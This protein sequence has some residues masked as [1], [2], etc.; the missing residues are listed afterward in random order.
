MPFQSE[1]PAPPPRTVDGALIQSSYTKE[2][3]GINVTR[4]MKSLRQS[5]MVVKYSLHVQSAD[6][7]FVYRFLLSFGVHRE[8]YQIIR[9][10]RSARFFVKTRHTE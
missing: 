2:D 1:T 10:E 8:N 7:A 9:I 6:I 4:I 5:I 3:G